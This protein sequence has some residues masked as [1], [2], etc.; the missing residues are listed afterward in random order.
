[1]LALGAGGLAA[2]WGVQKYLAAQVERL[3]DP[4]A[5]IPD[6]PTAR[7][8]DDGDEVVDHGAMNILVLGSD[9]RISAGDPTQWQY[10]AQRTDTI[11]LVHLPAARDAAYLMSIP[12]DSW[13]PVPGYGEQKINAAFAFGGPTLLIQTIEQLTDVRVDHFVV[14]DFDSFVRITDALGGV[15]MTLTKDLKVGD[16]VV[17]AGKQQLLTGE[18]AL[19]FVRER[20][21][22][23]RGDFDRVQHQQAWVRSIVAKMRNDGTLHNPVTSARFLDVVSRSVAT[24]DGLDE[25]VMRD[26]QDRAKDL[27]STDM[28]FFTVPFEGTGRSPD[29]AQSV[30][31]LDK[32]ALA[33]LMAAVADD[34]LGAY[35]AAHEAELDMLPPVVE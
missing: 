13:V 19:R 10:G 24:D 23:A 27:G 31:V 30:V 14:T 5:G 1:M 18:Q 4:F 33:E 3:G 21:S 22:L 35:V 25:A 26:L 28:R 20:K 29:G 32:P 17:P 15:R 6:R 2:T 34:T 12:R 11:M 16:T 8:T 7:A 9:S